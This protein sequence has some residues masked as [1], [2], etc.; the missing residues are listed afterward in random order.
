[1]VEG[2]PAVSHTEGPKTVVPASDPVPSSTQQDIPP[3][4]DHQRLALD[5]LT[6]IE[7]ISGLNIRSH[8]CRQ[9][10]LVHDDFAN[11]QVATRVFVAKRR[12]SASQRYLC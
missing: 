3:P 1:M 12:E 4:Q 6:V 10:T 11:A 9:M 5:G 7:R 2:N 8:S